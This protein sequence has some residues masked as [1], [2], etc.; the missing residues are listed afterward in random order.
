MFYLGKWSEFISYHQ[1][2]CC[3]LLHLYDNSLPHQNHSSRSSA[4]ETNRARKE[5]GPITAGTWGTLQSYKGPTGA[6]RRGCAYCSHSFSD[7]GPLLF[8]L[9]PKCDSRHSC[10]T[11]RA[12]DSRSAH[13]WSLH[14]VSWSGYQSSCIRDEKQGNTKHGEATISSGLKTSRIG[15]L[16]DKRTMLPW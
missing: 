11:W 8:V 7:S 2:C 12:R 16:S 4:Q 14:D 5:G 15:Y 13:V 6:K 1:L 9:G 10:V 3:F